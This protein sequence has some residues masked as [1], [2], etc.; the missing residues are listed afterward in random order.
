MFCDNS[1]IWTFLSS[2][3]AVEDPETARTAG[4]GLFLMEVFPAIALASIGDEFFGRLK[5]PRYNPDRRKTY[6]AADWI[7]VAEAAA[8]EAQTH[9]CEE[10][11]AWCSAAGRLS[12]PRK[13]DQDMLDAAICA[14][15]A[16]RWRRR[17]R[18][19]S[20]MLGDMMLGYMV[21]PASPQMREGLA[22][23]ARKC[24]VMVDGV[25]T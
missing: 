20:V 19:E 14:L 9:G 16:I 8:L 6:G 12:R 22:A 3:G 21:T 4:G 1:P 23:A 18:R 17:P 11:T 13:A 24:S 15:V 10:L 2:L 7:R 25:L 5:A